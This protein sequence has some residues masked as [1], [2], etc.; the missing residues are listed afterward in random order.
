ME[1]LFHKDI[2]ALNKAI[3]DIY[4]V[5]DMDSFYRQV[6]ASLKSLIPC[7]TISYNELTRQYHFTKGMH[8]TS[9]HHHFFKKVLHI[10]NDLVRQHPFHG[11]LHEE[12]AI[13]TSD[14]APIKRFK[15]TDL[16]NEYYRHIDVENQLS[17][18]LSTNKERP[19]IF[20]LNRKSSD[21]S[22]RDR[23]ILTLLRPHIIAAMR[24]VKEFCRLRLERDIL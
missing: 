24:N 10:W 5:R 4:A 22:E 12:R 1:T 15:D 3:G 6:F 18:G 16:Y 19:V 11:H 14:Y 20:C 13:K 8:D 17:A 9:V 7:D 23:L 2:L 21:F